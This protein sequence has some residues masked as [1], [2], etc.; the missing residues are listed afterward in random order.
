MKKIRVK[1]YYKYNIED[2]LK[3]KMQTFLSSIFAIFSVFHRIRCTQD[4]K[5]KKRRRVSEKMVVL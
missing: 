4:P 3:N 1:I 2:Y 5:D